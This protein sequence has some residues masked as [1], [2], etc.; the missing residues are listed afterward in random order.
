M[1]APMP[2]RTEPA[3]RAGPDRSRL[4]RLGRF[5]EQDPS[6]ANLLRDYAREAWRL[7]EPEA[8][9]AALGQLDR[10]GTATAVDH[11][12][13][14]FALR[15]LG[16]S[17]SAIVLL[18]SASARWP[19]EPEIA[20]ERARCLFALR[21]FEQAL[22][23][24]PTPVPRRRG[25]AVALRVR[26][27]HHLGRLDEALGEAAAYQGPLADTRDVRAATLPVLVDLSRLD[28]AVRL[29]TELTSPASDA[30]APPYE[31]A[32]PLALQA[33]DS[34][35]P[36]A[37]LGWVKVAQQQR[38]DDGR[39]WLVKGMAHLLARDFS[40]GAEALGQ[41]ASLM[42]AHPGS[43]LA[44]GWAHCL[45]GD[46]SSART[47]FERGIGASPGLADGQGSL[48]VLDVLDGRRDAAQTGIRKALK[49]DPD[50]ASARFA[51]AL[52][53]QPRG[54]DI[55]QLAQRVLARAR[56]P[57]RGAQRH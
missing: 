36:D 56:R 41:A 21:Q 11:L 18:Q 28:D 31:A 2:N 57:S 54:H 23:A 30:S 27:L 49:L 10:C 22:A 14:A 17:E 37:A 50:C 35:Q 6:N 32:E 33:L 29:A 8:A 16:R 40:V 4:E 52:L 15:Q 20:V 13:A 19:H 51:A 48:A 42:P 55:E 26:L 45:A 3:A 5:V 43:L 38:Q 39:I 46:R 34:Q 25:E 44:L 9:L 53:K 1:N 12:E 7:G 47:A 24:L